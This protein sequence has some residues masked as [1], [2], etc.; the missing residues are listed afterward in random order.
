M[1]A[2]SN[3]LELKILDHV[4]GPTSYTK[5]TAVYVGLFTSNPGED[6]LLT[7]EISG[8]NTGYTRRIATFSAADNGSI[9]N[10]TSINFNTATANWGTITHIAICDSATPGAGNVLFYGP[11]TT[12]KTIETG[13]VFQIPLGNLTVSLD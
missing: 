13:D 8:I 5:P 1:S 7:S 9:S 2:A 3:F 11:V 6:G 4:L 12:A 10:N